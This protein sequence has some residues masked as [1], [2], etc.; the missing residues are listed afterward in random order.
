MQVYLEIGI[1]AK[2]INMAK[3]QQKKVRVPSGPQAPQP[4]QQGPPQGTP[5]GAPPFKKGGEKKKGKK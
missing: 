5:G 1:L 4:G 3:Q 2:N